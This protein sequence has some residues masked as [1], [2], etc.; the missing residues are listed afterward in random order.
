FPRGF[1]LRFLALSPPSASSSCPLILTHRART[2]PRHRS[3]RLTGC[4]SYFL[5]SAPLWHSEASLIVATSPLRL[6]KESPF[7]CCCHDFALF[8]RSSRLF[9]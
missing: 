8:N 6:T 2:Y 1:A 3:R 9:F 7:G 4:V 5:K